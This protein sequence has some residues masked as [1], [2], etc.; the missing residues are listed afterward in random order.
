MGGI[1]LSCFGLLGFPIGTLI[2][3][4]FLYLLSSQKGVY[5]FSPEYARVIAATPHIKYKTSIIGW[6]LLGILVFFIGLG[7]IG[8][9]VSVIGGRR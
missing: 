9:M 2:S 6:I 1:V 4:Y 5:I 3:A 7:I 8:L